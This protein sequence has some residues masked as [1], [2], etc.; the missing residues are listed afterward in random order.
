MLT[1]HLLEKRDQ[2]KKI[3]GQIMGS[4]EKNKILRQN[5]LLEKKTEERNA[6]QV[7]NFPKLRKGSVGGHDPSA[8]PSAGSVGT[9]F[10][11][12]QQSLQFRNQ[13]RVILQLE[14]IWNQGKIPPSM[15]S[16]PKQFYKKQWSQPSG[17][18]LEMPVRKK[19]SDV[20]ALCRTRTLTILHLQL[21][22]CKNRSLSPTALILHPPPNM[23][24]G[25]IINS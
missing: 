23:E 21:L 19:T 1:L 5:P 22:S 18:G 3:K 24:A 25:A 13:L 4:V 12:H 9:R 14:Q 7:W 11:K 15:L 10:Q 20:T 8:G 16:K 2:S 6:T 17:L